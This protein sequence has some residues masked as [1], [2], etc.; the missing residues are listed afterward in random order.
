[1]KQS[2]KDNIKRILSIVLCVVLLAGIYYIQW[3]SS[4]P[5]VNPDPPI[6]TEIKVVENGQYSSKDEVALYINQFGKLPSNFMTKKEA[7]KQGWKSGALDTV[8]AGYSIGGDKYGNNEGLLPTKEGRQY[9]V[10]D[11]DTVGQQERGTKRIVFSNDGLIY[12]TDDFYASFE[13]LY[14]DELPLTTP[15][16]P[17]QPDN[18][19][20]PTPPTPPA[21]GEIVVVE[22]GQYTS[23]DEVALYI[24]LFGKLP[25][26]FMTKKEAK[27]YGWSSGALDR[28]V[29]GYSIGGDRFGNNEGLLPTKS[30]RYYTECDI[31]TIGEKSRGAKRIVFSNDGLIYYTEDHY[32]TFELLYGEP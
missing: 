5:P 20:P 23:K 14:G 13:L 16:K 30:G 25:S 6:Q 24:H 4:Q 2:K 19:T 3:K 10:C 8:I 18:P 27:K 22:D 12:Y 26:N 7:E 17:T 29:P 1:M 11:I 28:V 15:V 31:D 32:E 9:Y 21:T